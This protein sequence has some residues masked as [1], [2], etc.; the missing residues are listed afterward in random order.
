MLFFLTCLNTK[1]F[2]GYD[3]DEFG[4]L[5]INPKEAEIVK[6]IFEWYV[7]GI[8]CTEIARKLTDKG[9]KTVTGLKEWNSATI[10]SILKNEKYKGDAILQKTYVPDHIKKKAIENKGE[11]DKY[12]LADDH[13][14]IVSRETWDIAQEIMAQSNYSRGVINDPKY[15]NKYPYTGILYCSKCG[16]PLRRKVW[17]SK[18]P[19]KKY[20]WQCSNYINKSKRTCTG[21]KIDEKELEKININGPII[22]GEVLRDGKKY[23]SYTSNRE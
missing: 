17:N 8:R 13:P 6:D 15:N 3:K 21:T 11:L 18:T 10:P 12:Y 22:I 9:I 7:S 14:P 1:R 19:F 4:G 20:V 5:M 2:L 16:A 23:Y